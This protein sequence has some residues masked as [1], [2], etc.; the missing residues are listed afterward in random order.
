MAKRKLN[1]IQHSHAPVAIESNSRRMFLRGLGTTLALPFLP[2]LFSENAYAA[3][4]ADYRKAAFMIFSHG[5]YWG[6]WAP[7]NVNLTQVAANVRAGSLANATLGIYFPSDYANIRNKITILQGLD[8]TGITGHAHNSS[9][10]AGGHSGGNDFEFARSPNSIDVILSKS[11][12]VYSSEP[13]FRVL[14]LGPYGFTFSH[15]YENGSGITFSTSDAQ[16]FFNIVKTGLTAA[17]APASTT[18]TSSGLSDQMRAAGR[19]KLMVDSSFNSIQALLN[20]NKI[21]AADKNVAQNFFDYLRDIQTRTN[22]LASGGGG[23][24]STP[25]PPS[26]LT[27]NANYQ[28]TDNDFDKAKSQVDLMILAMACGL[29]K[30]SYF[31]LPSEHDYVHNVNQ[32][33]QRLAHANY[34]RTE[35]ALLASYAMNK[36]DSITEGNGKTMLDNSAVVHTSDIGASKYD[37]HCGLNLPIVVGGGLNGMLKQ[38]QMISYYNTTQT[39]ILSNYSDFGNGD[40]IYGGRPYNELLISIMRSFGLTTEYVNETGGYGVYDCQYNGAACTSSSSSTHAAMVDY[41][42][43]VFLPNYRNKNMGLPY[44]YM[45][46]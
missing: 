13:Y 26:T 24:G 25:P 16:S 2:S 14:R 9:L 22:T 41:Y 44:Y 43:K 5:A 30:L 21:S 32:P 35:S 6:N 31:S 45:G 3:V 17:T 42:A 46:T 7:T 10:A 39:P 20:G 11:T 18:S 29:T 8:M 4:A 37:N 33:D 19:K 36:M 28:A 38:G 34:I 15:C 12:K 1:L 40:N 27:C 23:G